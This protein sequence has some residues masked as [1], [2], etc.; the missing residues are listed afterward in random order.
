MLFHDTDQ[1]AVIQEVK[2][3]TKNE[4]SE[5]IQTEISPFDGFTLAE[6]R[7]QKYFLKR[8]PD[9]VRR[10]QELYPSFDSFNNATL[11]A[12]LNSF[13]KGCV[14]M[15]DLLSEIREWQIPE[16]EQ[17]KLVAIVKGIRW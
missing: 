17:E 4:L 6:E 3:Q 5:E 8:Y 1:L 10:L 2:N 11:A 14:K 16:A 7:H 15:A 13:V 12:R 9:A